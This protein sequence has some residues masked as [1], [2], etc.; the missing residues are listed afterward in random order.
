MKLEERFANAPAPPDT[1]DLDR[2]KSQ[3]E[4]LKLEKEELLK[5]TAGG[6]KG[7]ESY[8]LVKDLSN[9]NVK[10]RMQIVQLQSQLSSK[11]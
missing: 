10:L 3:V 11:K 5:F 1:R 6:T 2:L 4:S 8:T 7:G 9:E